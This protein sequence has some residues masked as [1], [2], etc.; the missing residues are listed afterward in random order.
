MKPR[1]ARFAWIPWQVKLAFD[2]SY[3]VLGAISVVGGFLVGFGV[4]A[5]P[6]SSFIGGAVLVLLGRWLFEPVDWW[7]DELDD[8]A[9]HDPDPWLDEE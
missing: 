4:F 5:P 8:P 6:S 7:G 9:R 3:I 1:N 2:L